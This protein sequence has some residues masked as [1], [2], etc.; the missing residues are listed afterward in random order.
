MSKRL[1][2]K[3][4][5]RETKNYVKAVVIEAI[6]GRVPELK[7]KLLTDFKLLEDIAT[8]GESLIDIEVFK[9][10]FTSKVAAFDF[11]PKD[12]DGFTLRIPSMDNFDF[13]GIEF[14][15]AVFEGIV[16]T[17]A[18]ATTIDM[19]RLYGSFEDYT[20]INKGLQSEPVYFIPVTEWLVN[21][22]K[23]ILGY[24]LIRSP[25][26]DTEPLVDLIFGPTQKYVDNNMSSWISQA[27][28]RSLKEVVTVYGGK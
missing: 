26:S 25:F 4:I 28:A 1:Y 13:T 9:N 21:Q 10:A 22:E 2:K 14:L 24:S 16:G 19:V 3:R 23:M 15:E 8:A 27:I 20:P 17:F 11:I 5:K 7:T 18:E 6:K 12:D